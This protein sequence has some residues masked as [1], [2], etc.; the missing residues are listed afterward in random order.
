MPDSQF[1]YFDLEFFS[2]DISRLNLH[3]LAVNVLRP[4]PS[5]DKPAIVANLIATVLNGFDDMQGASA[6]RSDER[7]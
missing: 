5:I 2:A 3:A 7:I 1:E 4:D 6:P